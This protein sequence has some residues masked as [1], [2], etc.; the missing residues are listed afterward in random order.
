M[1]QNCETPQDAKVWWDRLTAQDL[2]TTVETEDQD[3]LRTARDLLPEGPV[4]EDT[5]GAWTSALKAET[6]R[7]GRGLFMPLRKA[8]T[9]LDHGPEMGPL[10][11]LIG[12]DKVRDRLA[13]SAG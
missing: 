2:E 4:S 1:R 7:K 9:G 12:R 11:V 8:L 10:L 6:G 13:K 5:W 3:Y